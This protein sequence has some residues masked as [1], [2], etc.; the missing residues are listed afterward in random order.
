M[1]HF[2]HSER[3]VE[4]YKESVVP[5][6]GPCRLLF[7]DVPTKWSSTY[8]SMARLYTS[9]SRLS[10]FFASPDVGAGARNQQLT[11]S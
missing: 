10:V 7:T 3:S 5:H 6:N 1:E 11:S 9:Y 4:I 2:N 8:I